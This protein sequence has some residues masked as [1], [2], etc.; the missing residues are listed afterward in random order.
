MVGISSHGNDE[1]I[2]GQVKGHWTG[3][4]WRLDERGR[5]KWLGGKVIEVEVLMISRS[6]STEDEQES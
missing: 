6:Q 2:L 5:R 4:A 1:K 3:Y